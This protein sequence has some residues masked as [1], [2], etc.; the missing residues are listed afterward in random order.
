[1]TQGSL[2]EKL[3]V[4]RARRGLTL[5]EAAK[6]AGITPDTLSELER[7]KRHAYTPT[8]A[9]IAKGYGVPVE[10]LLGEAVP[11]AQRLSDIEAS[12]RF[13]EWLEK[14]EPRELLQKARRALERMDEAIRKTVEDDA[15]TLEYVEEMDEISTSIGESLYR[16]FGLMA[17]FD[18]LSKN[19]AELAELHAT[20][21]SRF[22]ELRA[23]VD[24][25]WKPAVDKHLGWADTRKSDDVTGIDEK[26]QK[27]AHR[28][29]QL[30]EL[31]AVVG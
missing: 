23:T 7:D 12:R 31:K 18:D 14:E 22:W 3:R 6:R 27:R 21:Q 15:A 25:A 11:L 19:D 26:E 8:L 29:Q 16:K 20:T 1:M 9:K 13:L 24:A 2:A 4:L 10:E 17:G 5:A 28:H 30:E